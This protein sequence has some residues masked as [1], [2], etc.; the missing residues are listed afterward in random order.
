MKPTN[1][2]LYRPSSLAMRDRYLEP[3]PVF[4]ETVLSVV[5]GRT[6]TGAPQLT[7]ERLVVLCLIPVERVKDY[8]MAVKPAVEAVVVDDVPIEDVVI[9][10]LLQE[11]EDE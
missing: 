5:A 10:V 7:L 9:G 4:D 6:E 11:V 2:T 8:E 3:T 1:N